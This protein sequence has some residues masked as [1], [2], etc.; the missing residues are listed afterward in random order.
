[1]W[2]QRWILSTMPGATE[3]AVGFA[4][5]ASYRA[6]N[7]LLAGCGKQSLDVAING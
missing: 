5:G 1:M 3:D 7:P 6:T 2:S 4:R